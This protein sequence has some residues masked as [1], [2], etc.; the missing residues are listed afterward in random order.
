DEATSSIDSETEARLQ[1]ALNRLL[2]GRTSFVVAHRLSTIRHADQ[3]I[4][5]D[6]GRI[7]E[8]GTHDEL[9]SREGHYAALYQ[10][11]TGAEQSRE[12]SAPLDL[13]GRLYS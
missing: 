12:S 3:V 11:F 5:L 8:R 2:R 4:V 1:N 6:H 10:R 7:L 9:I 13:P